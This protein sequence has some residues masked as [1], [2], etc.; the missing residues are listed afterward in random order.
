MDTNAPN[1]RCPARAFLSQ[2]FEPIRL[3]LL[4]VD[5]I[6]LLL[7]GG[8]RTART[9]RLWTLDDNLLH[10][11]RRLHLIRQFHNSQKGLPCS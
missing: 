2:S 9:I 3:T 10:T 4:G 5:S 8:R 7:C 11:V 6:R 1:L